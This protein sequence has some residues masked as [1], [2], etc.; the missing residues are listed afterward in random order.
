MLVS[1]PGLCFPPGCFL[2]EALFMVFRLDSLES[3][4][5]KVCKSCRYRQ[6]L[7]KEYLLAKVGVDTAENG[8]L[9]VCQK[10]VVAKSYKI[11]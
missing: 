3:K 2:Q 11:S 1:S 8:P 7:S 4:G 9:D 6:E 5:A 10:L